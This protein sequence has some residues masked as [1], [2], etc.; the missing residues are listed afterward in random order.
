[1]TT[2]NSEQDMT[3]RCINTI[4]M[5]SVDAVEKA[6]S[7]HPGLPMGDAAPAYTLWTAFLRHNPR[8]PLRLLNR[9]FHLITCVTVHPLDMPL[10]RL[11]PFGDILGEGYICRAFDGDAVVEVDVDNLPQSEIARH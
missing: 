6:K 4:R 8:N 5:L 11:E 10:V 3:E 2:Q 9:T 1:M 7:G